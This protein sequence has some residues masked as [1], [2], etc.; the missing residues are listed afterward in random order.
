MFLF[1]WFIDKE[2]SR[3]P[4]K[5]DVI[6]RSLVIFFLISHFQNVKQVTK[7]DYRY[8]CPITSVILQICIIFPSFSLVI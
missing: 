7:N 3:T 4:E 1:H 5:I 2:I 8:G 6:P